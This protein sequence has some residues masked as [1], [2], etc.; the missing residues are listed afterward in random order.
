LYHE[1]PA[2][3]YRSQVT[4]SLYTLKGNYSQNLDH[5]SNGF[6]KLQYTPGSD[7]HYVFSIN[8]KSYKHLWCSLH[9]FDPS[10]YSITNMYTPPSVNMAP[11]LRKRS[12]LVIGQGSAGV[13]PFTFTVRPNELHDA[14]FM[15]LFISEHH[16]DLTILDQAGLG[17]ND[18]AYVTRHCRDRSVDHGKWDTITV[19]V[20]V[21]RVGT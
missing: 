13:P 12:F 14:G 16:A 17:E 9:Y 5:I 11:P 19:I 1:N 7:E 3:P 2:H 6:A 10:D 4:L 15:K 21:H 20:D 18:D 8:N